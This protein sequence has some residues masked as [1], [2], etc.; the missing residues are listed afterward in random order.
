ML[1]VRMKTRKFDSQSPSSHTFG[2]ECPPMLPP[3]LESTNGS[4]GTRFPRFYSPAKGDTVPLPTANLYQLYRFMEIIV[5]VRPHICRLCPTQTI[6]N[7]PLT[8]RIG[9]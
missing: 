8:F 6:L 2:P 9:A 1:R 7:T 5:S 4:P 3:G